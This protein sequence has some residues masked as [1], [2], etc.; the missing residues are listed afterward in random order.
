MLT[1][2]DKDLIQK[3]SEKRPP[4][5]NPQSS[6]SP[7]QQLSCGHRVLISFERTPSG[8]DF[9][10]IRQSGGRIFDSDRRPT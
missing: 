2:V 9:M 3:L 10:L 1:Y 8:F 4:G 5:M 6:S 7:D